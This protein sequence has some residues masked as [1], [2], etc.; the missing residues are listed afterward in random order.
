ML[1]V[2]I[3]HVIIAFKFGLSIIIKD[4]PSWVSNEEKVN[5]DN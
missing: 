4:K 2:L 1:I 5:Y 3:E